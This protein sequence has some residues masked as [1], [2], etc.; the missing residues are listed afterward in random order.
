MPPLRIQN[1]GDVIWAPRLVGKP[2]R[3]WKQ[4]WPKMLQAIAR[5]ADQIDVREYEGGRNPQIFQ[6][7]PEESGHKFA[8][9]QTAISPDVLANF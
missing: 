7:I 6:G 4:T 1:A 8:Y 3:A 9:F 5:G 2:K